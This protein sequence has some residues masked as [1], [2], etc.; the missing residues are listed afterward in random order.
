MK[1]R[2]ILL[3][4]L[5][6]VSL[7]FAG[8]L[9]QL[10]TV[11]PNLVRNQIAVF[12]NTPTPEPLDAVVLLLQPEKINTVINQ[13][14]VIKLTYTRL[15][16]PLQG[17]DLILTYDPN[18][19]EFRQVQNLHSQFLNTRALVDPTS[20]RLIVSFLEKQNQPEL[21][22]TNLVMA[23]LLF[24]AKKSGQTTLTPVLNSSPN[25]S[26]AIIKGNTHNKL[27]SINPVIINVQ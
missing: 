12:K 22:E 8:L 1:R 13:P 9:W 7:L 18:E 20:N 16:R 27:I 26:L 14:V 5:I 24:V 15:K 11:S 19:L 25:S 4:V 21:T 17:A 3:T 6:I 10:I 23:E 2:Q